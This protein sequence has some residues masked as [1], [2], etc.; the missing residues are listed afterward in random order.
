MVNPYPDGTTFRW[1]AHCSY[2]SVRHPRTHFY[3]GKRH[4]ML[5][6]TQNQKKAQKRTDWFAA[7][8]GGVAAMGIAALSMTAGEA[9]AANEPW[10]ENYTM[11][12]PYGDQPGETNRAFNPSTRD[13]NGNRVVSNTFTQFSNTAG[14]AGEGS[15]V[16]TSGIYGSALAVGNQLNVVTNGNNNTVIVNSTQINNGDQEAVLN[17]TLDLD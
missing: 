16:G 6:S 9:L 11:N 3:E 12:T 14:V 1:H 2:R 8:A 10:E 7:V 4:A 17:G 15:G 5:G 13:A